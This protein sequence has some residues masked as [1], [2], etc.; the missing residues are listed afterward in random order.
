MILYAL[1]ESNS[2]Q[3]LL[4]KLLQKEHDAGWI[5]FWYSAL[6]SSLYGSARMVLGVWREPAVLVL[7]ANSTYPE[8]ADRC[9]LGAE[10]VIGEVAG[11]APLRVLV[12]VP[13]LHAL[14]FRRPDAVARVYGQ[15]SPGLLELGQISPRDALA[16]LDQNVSIHEAVCKLIL[17]LNDQ[18]IDALRAE[19]PIRDLLEFLV[20]L[21]R[22]AVLTTTRS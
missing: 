15:I 18:D 9:R 20:E 13:A 5:K 22:D 10:E 3:T 4:L 1:T 2:N 21:Q 12:A 17:E 8:V 14:L 6:P 19:S 16:K 7:D 11:V